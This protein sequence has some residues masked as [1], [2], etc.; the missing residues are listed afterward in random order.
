MRDYYTEKNVFWVPAEARWQMLHDCLPPDADTLGDVH[1][2][3]RKDAVGGR[4]H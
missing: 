2:D 4:P 3:A 1:G